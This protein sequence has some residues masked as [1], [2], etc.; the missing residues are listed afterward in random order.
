MR[1]CRV[2]L[3]LLAMCLLA[4][5]PRAGRRQK[6]DGQTDRRRW[7][8]GQGQRQ[9]I[10]R[11]R[12]RRQIGRRR[13]GRRRQGPEGYRLERVKR[14]SSGTSTTA[15]ITT[16]ARKTC[17]LSLIAATAKSVW[18]TENVEIPWEANKSA[19]PGAGRP[20]RPGR[21]AAGRNHRLERK[22]GRPVRDRSPRQDRHEFGPGG[23]VKTSDERS[24]S[25]PLGG[26]ALI[27]GNYD[28]ASNEAGYWL[29]PDGTKGW[30]EIEL[31]PQKIPPPPLEA[32]GS[33]ERQERSSRAR[34]CR[35]KFWSLATTPSICT[36]T[37]STLC[38]ATA[39]RC[40]T[41]ALF[42]RQRR[43][44]H[45]QM[46]GHFRHQGGILL[47]DQLRQRPLLLSTMNGWKQL[48]AGQSGPVVHARAAQ[49]ATDRRT[50]GSRTGPKRK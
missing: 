26:G 37:A 12:C 15:S 19:D 22:E 28:S 7:Q 9:E 36:S 11:R 33:Q 13:V 29:L 16:A 32:Q 44:H 3:L 38:P 49:A 4:P 47:P 8:I 25:D 17:N 41:R 48:H 43:R 35:P 14:S 1:H 46:R 50:R 2:A 42:D 34:R 6:P 27:D 39:S 23:K 30:A 5:R 45:R 20:R 31:V 24:P 40:F 21:R 10:G 18:H